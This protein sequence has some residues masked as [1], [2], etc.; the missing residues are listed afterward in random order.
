MRSAVQHRTRARIEISFISHVVQRTGKGFRCSF[1]AA[2]SEHLPRV[3]S[4]RYRPSARPACHTGARARASFL[5]TRCHRAAPILSHMRGQSSGRDRLENGCIV[6]RALSVGWA[7][8]SRVML[9]INNLKILLVFQNVIDN[10][11]K[12]MYTIVVEPREIERYSEESTKL[13]KV[14]AGRRSLAPEGKRWRQARATEVE[15]TLRSP[16]KSLGAHPFGPSV[17]AT[18]PR[19]RGRL[20]LCTGLAVS[21]GTLIEIARTEPPILC[22]AERHG[23]FA[24][25]PGVG[26]VSG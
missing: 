24:P 9:N 17:L 8:H 16:T 11:C 10:V 13:L 12:T 25:G 6:L 15:R 2:A 22:R 5:L 20:L 18:E 19:R 4:V 7:V 3:M 14:L 23:L 26:T 21:P 1:V